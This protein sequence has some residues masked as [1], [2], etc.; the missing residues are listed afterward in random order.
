MFYTGVLNRRTNPLLQWPNGG[1]SPSDT[2]RFFT[3][4]EFDSLCLVTPSWRYKQGGARAITIPFNISNSTGYSLL[5]V[6][7][8]GGGIDTVVGQDRDLS[9]NFLPG[10]GKI[11]KVTILPPDNSTVRTPQLLKPSESL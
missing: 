2:L 4:A 8:L 1:S 3:T 6:Q 7:E 11:S 10:E 9:V 5:R